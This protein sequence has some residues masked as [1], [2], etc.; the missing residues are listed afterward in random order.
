M[1]KILKLLNK[2]FAPTVTKTYYYNN[3]KVDKFPKEAEDAFKQMDRMMKYM[4]EIF[5]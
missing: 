1:I 2:I 4:N 3:K 5:K